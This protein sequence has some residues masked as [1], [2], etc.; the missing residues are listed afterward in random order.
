MKKSYEMPL[1]EIINVDN[2]DIIT[3]SSDLGELDFGK[4]TG[5]NN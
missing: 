3:S 5:E 1:V 4:L 2:A